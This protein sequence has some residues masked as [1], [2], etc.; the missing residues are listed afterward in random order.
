MGT[1]AE[2]LSDDKG[3]IWP[4]EVAPYQVSLVSLA[5]DAGEKAKADEIFGKLLSAGVETF[6]DDRDDLRAGE[7]FGD[8]DLIG[9]P[10]RVIV[11]GKTLAQNGV[12]F[13]RRDSATAEV[14]SLD[15]MVERIK[16]GGAP[17]EVG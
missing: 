6:Y 9:L 11:S 2:C 7:K 13:K 1:I 3:L 10:F 8:A 16:S 12:E 5:R 14:I 15:A 17:T 4:S